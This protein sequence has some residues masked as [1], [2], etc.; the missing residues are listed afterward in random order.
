MIVA[1]CAADDRANTAAEARSNLRMEYPFR[2]KLSNQVTNAALKEFDSV[3]VNR[4]FEDAV[5]D[6]LKIL[7]GSG[8]YGPDRTELRPLIAELLGGAKPHIDPAPFS[9]AR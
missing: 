9:P 5:S 1:A 2:F 6:L 4:D 3:V 7:R 8:G